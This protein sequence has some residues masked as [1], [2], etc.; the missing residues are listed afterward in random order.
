MSGRR[1]CLIGAGVVVGAIGFLQVDWW[2]RGQEPAGAKDELVELLDARVRAFLDSVSQGSTQ[3]AF[4][5]LLRGSPLLLQKGQALKTLV[6]RAAQISNRFG[7]F[8]GFERVDARRVGKDLV[9]LRYLYKCEDFPIVWSITFYR[10]ISQP[11]SPPDES[12]WRVIVV[13][14]DTEVEQLVR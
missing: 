10:P 11:D 1:L 13:R 3:Q 2:V 12:A 5:N 4:E 14:F 9:F 8:R 7:R 6:E